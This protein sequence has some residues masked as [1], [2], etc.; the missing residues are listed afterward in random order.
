MPRKIFHHLRLVAIRLV[1]IVTLPLAFLAIVL[2]SAQP[3]LSPRAVPALP[4]SELWSG[5]TYTD[6]YTLSVDHPVALIDQPVTGLC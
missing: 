2:I 4:P 3:R 6:I 5:W 1:V